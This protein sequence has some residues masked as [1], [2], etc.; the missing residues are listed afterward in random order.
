MN[1][2]EQEAKSHIYSLGFWCV[3]LANG[4]LGAFTHPAN[5][6]FLGVFDRPEQ[7]P[8]RPS[9]PTFHFTP[10]LPT[11]DLGDIDL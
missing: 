3:P 10:S 7:V 11:V 5:P 4:R 1:P 2:E 8:P 9:A 6:E